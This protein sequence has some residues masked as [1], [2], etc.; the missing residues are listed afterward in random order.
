MT[1]IW[2]PIGVVLIPAAPLGFWTLAEEFVPG[3]RLL[4][5]LTLDETPER[6]P[7]AFAWSPTSE[8]Q[9]GPDGD[10]QTSKT[11]LLFTGAAYGA[12]IGKI[13][14]STADLPETFTGTSSPYGN[15]KVF[16]VGSEAI[17]TLPTAADGG[18]LFLTMNDKPEEFSKHSGELLVSI[19]Y[20]PI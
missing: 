18:P 4:R 19:D 5:I 17:I 3:S 14:G 8:V 12:L 6:I 16:A 7:V 2:Q 10:F 20:Y 11:G 1:L 13:S 15:K 9:C